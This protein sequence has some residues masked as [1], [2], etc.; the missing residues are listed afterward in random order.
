MNEK[1]E[2]P[3]QVNVGLLWERKLTYRDG[4][5]VV[6][7]PEDRVPADKSGHEVGFEVIPTGDVDKIEN[8]IRPSETIDGLKGFDETKKAWNEGN[9]MLSHLE[10]I[11]P[12]DY[13]ELSGSL[14]TLD[15]LVNKYGALASKPKRNLLDK[16]NMIFFGSNIKGETDEVSNRLK[17]LGEMFDKCDTPEQARAETMKLIENCTQRLEGDGR[18]AMELVKA[19]VYRIRGDVKQM[20]ALPRAL[21]GFKKSVEQGQNVSAIKVYLKFLEIEA[22]ILP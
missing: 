13:E 11:N 22:E 1:M 21:L 2:K 20:F 4:R 16:I 15:G 5:G 9:E 3:V 18:K 14:D 19:H 10:K 8:K 12:P 6:E 17:L 7:G